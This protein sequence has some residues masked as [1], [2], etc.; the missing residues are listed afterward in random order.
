M[1]LRQLYR[2]LLGGVSSWDR[3]SK[4]SLALALILLLALLALGFGGPPA[5]QFPARIGAFGTL[6]SLQLLLFYANRRSISPYHQAQR[7]Y[8]G[9]DY[10][11]ARGILEEQAGSSR[12]SVDA[13]VLLGN[14]CRQLGQFDR[15]R[16][17][18]G[19]ARELK[20]DYHYALYAA[21]KLSLI[22]GDYAAAVEQLERALNSGT[23]DIAL[24]DLGQ[25]C[26]LLGER[27]P[28]DEC[29]KRFLASDSDEP[30]KAMLA[31]HYRH[32]MGRDEAPSDKE[33]KRH[34]DAWRD[35]ARRYQA[36][37]YGVSLSRELE[38]L[39]ASQ[40]VT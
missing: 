39:S 29:F 22:T 30:A 20:P 27:A 14:A 16:A 28:A 10:A 8:M 24:F 31:R 35:E 23:P 34:I 33:I 9:G 3:A 15:S 32:V 18:I 37:A 4:L 5:L 26:C 2:D 17:V 1:N 19:R 38:R 21:G 40:R 11:A 13:L 25:A 12:E 36:T 6:L 7:L